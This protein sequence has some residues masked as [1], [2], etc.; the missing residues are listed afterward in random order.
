MSKHRSLPLW[1]GSSKSIHKEI[2]QN[3]LSLLELPTGEEILDEEMKQV[4]TNS[5]NSEYEE[6]E[7]YSVEEFKWSMT[8]TIWKE[9][10]QALDE[11]A[12]GLP[13]SQLQRT[14]RAS[15]Q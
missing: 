14:K 1:S 8:A 12:S 2:T 15:F 10:Q 7:N 5:Q 9:I 11:D 3:D 13:G 6:I 4:E